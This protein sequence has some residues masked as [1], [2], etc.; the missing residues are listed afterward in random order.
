MNLLGYLEHVMIVLHLVDVVD[1]VDVSYVV[2]VHV[3]MGMG[4]NFIYFESLVR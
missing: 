3:G 4:L 2:S 1:V